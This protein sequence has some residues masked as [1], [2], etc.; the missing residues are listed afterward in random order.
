V[1]DESHS[2]GTHGANGEGLVVEL[3]LAGQVHFRTASLAKA[4]AGR[5]GFIACGNGANEYIKSESFPTIFSSA[6]L[7]HDIAGLQAAL[8]VIHD[9]GWRREQ[10][11]LKA[12][13]LRERLDELGYNLNNSASQIM[14]LESGTEQQ[15]IILRDALES[16]GVFGSVF[17]APATPKTRSAIRLSVNAMLSEAELESVVQVCRDIRDEVDLPSWPSTR[18]RRLKAKNP[19]KAIMPDSQ[20]SPLYPLIG[21]L[22]ERQ[23]EEAISKA[24]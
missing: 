15:T 2:L 23:A 14:S 24:A 6:L 8:E 4:F 5:A 19:G 10:L 3:G 20:G 11:H 1:V 12:T 17:C 21:N 9:E 18:R 22:D 7:P 13:Y 16:R